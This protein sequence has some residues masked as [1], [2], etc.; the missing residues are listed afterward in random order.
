MTP[1]SGDQAC[2]SGRPTGQRP[3]GQVGIAVVSQQHA[4]SS[5]AATRDRSEQDQ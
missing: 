4:S 3:G 5:F 1:V 2:R